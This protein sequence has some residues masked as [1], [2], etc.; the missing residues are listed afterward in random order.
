MTAIFADIFRLT[1]ERSCSIGVASNTEANGLITVQENSLDRRAYLG[2]PRLQHFSRTGSSSEQ[3]RVVENELASADWIYPTTLL[4]DLLLSY[5]SM[6]LVDYTW[7]TWLTQ[8]SAVCTR[9]RKLSFY[10]KNA[11][12]SI[13]RILPNGKHIFNMLK[14]HEILCITLPSGIELAFDPVGSRYRWME[15]L[16]PLAD[17]VSQRVQFSYFEREIKLLGEKSV[18]FILSLS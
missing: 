2:S 1:E 3:W 8:P 12:K 7:Y 11:Y 6:F 16:S 18:R 10:P 5:M 9:S 4:V 14:R 15:V 13:Q 17:Y